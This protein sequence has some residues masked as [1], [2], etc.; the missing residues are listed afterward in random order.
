MNKID[1]IIEEINAERADHY[2]DTEDFNLGLGLAA[3][4]IRE[5]TKGMVLVPVEP[6]QAKVGLTARG[7]PMPQTVEEW[8][9]LYGLA[10][11]GM[12]EDKKTIERLQ[13]KINQLEQ[14][15]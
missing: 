6:T 11:Q 3:D 2:A 8:R 15:K 14:R 5:A 10:E 4:I 9:Y 12:L 1:S 7:E 13:L